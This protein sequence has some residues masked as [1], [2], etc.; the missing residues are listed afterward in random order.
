MVTTP[1]LS[2]LNAAVTLELESRVNDVSI[3]SIALL[4]FRL[5]MST[6]VTL[7]DTV[8]GELLTLPIVTFVALSRSDPAAPVQWIVPVEVGAVIV[9]TI[10]ADP[11]DR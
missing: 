8:M 9:G 2:T 3:T 10:V 11:G 5:L 1:Y 6:D 7:E 4:E